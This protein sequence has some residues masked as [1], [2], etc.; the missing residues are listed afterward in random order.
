MNKLQKSSELKEAMNHFKSL[1]N[2]IEDFEVWSTT[3][4][5][6]LW[7]DAVKAYKRGDMAGLQLSIIEVQRIL[8]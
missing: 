6:Q 7:D 3:P 2:I 1:M 8:A 5:F 4:H